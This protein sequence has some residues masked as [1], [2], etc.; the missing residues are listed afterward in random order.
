MTISD[1]ISIIAN[2]LA[3]QGRTPTVALIKGKL[4]QPTPLPRIISVLKSWQHEPD[5]VKAKQD[6]IKSSRQEITDPKHE[7]V[8]TLIAQAILPLQQELAEVKA[9]LE[10]LMSKQ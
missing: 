10:Q 7:E 5:F 9:L 4:S 1:E 3:N 2:Q 6:I 8:S